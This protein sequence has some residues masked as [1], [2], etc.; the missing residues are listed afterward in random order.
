[1]YAIRSYYGKAIVNLLSLDP[2]EKVSAFLPV[3]EFS[4]GRFVLFATARGVVKK[5]ALTEYSRPRPSGIIAI[6]RNNFV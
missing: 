2:G 4:E 6:N 3:R 1:M 5:T